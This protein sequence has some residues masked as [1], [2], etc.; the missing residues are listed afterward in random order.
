M[1]FTICRDRE[2]SHARLVMGTARK[3]EKTVLI[4]M[5]PEIGSLDASWHEGPKLRVALAKS[6]IRRLYGH[7]DNLPHIAITEA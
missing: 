4:D 3:P 6:A 1:E 2:Q 5:S 7:Y